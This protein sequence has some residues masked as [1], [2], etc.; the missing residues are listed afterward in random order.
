MAE[1][2]ELQENRL[3]SVDNAITQI[4]RQ[5]GKGAVMRAYEEN[6]T[7]QRVL[8]SDMFADWIEPLIP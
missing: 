7:T 6:P 5:F 1:R 4:Q 8:L 3:K 2:S